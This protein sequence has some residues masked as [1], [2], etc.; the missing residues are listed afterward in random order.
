MRKHTAAEMG[1]SGQIRYTKP[2]A[3]QMGIQENCDFFPGHIIKNW[4][5]PKKSGTDD[6]LNLHAVVQTADAVFTCNFN[7]T[8]D[9]ATERKLHAMCSIPQPAHLPQRNLIRQ[10]SC[11]SLFGIFETVPFPTF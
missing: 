10:F 1:K 2:K 5:C 8:H 7:V 3:G 6:H 9:T 4:D 11:S